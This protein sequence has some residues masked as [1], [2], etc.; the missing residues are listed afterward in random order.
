MPT[1]GRR[2]D[3]NLVQELAM[4]PNCWFEK[5]VHTDNDDIDM[6]LLFTHGESDYNLV[7]VRIWRL[8]CDEGFRIRNCI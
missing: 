6:S 3:P 5:A 1:A 2:I 8:E 7:T 4:R